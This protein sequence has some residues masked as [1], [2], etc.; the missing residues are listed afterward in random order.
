MTT[1]HLDP[2]RVVVCV[3]ARD[4]A[5]RLPRLIDA[6][7]SQDWP[8]PF[9]VV[10]A[11][12]NT[13]DASR[14]VMDGLTARLRGR[15]AVHVDETV[16]PPELAHAGSARRRAM[17][18]GLAMLGNDDGV[19]VTTDADACPPP[20]WVSANVAAIERGVDLVGGALVLDE[21]EPVSTLV[22]ARWAALAAY[23]AEVR[24]IEDDFDP[25]PWDPPPRHGDNTGG[26]LAVTAAAYRAAGGVP[27]RPTG[28][29]W[30]FVMAAQAAGA[31]L[32]H[33]PDVWVRVS[34]RTAGRASGGMAAAMA[35]LGDPTSHALR[36][37]SFDLWRER[38]LWRRGLRSRVGGDALVATLEP[39]LPPMPC[40]LRLEAP[41]PTE[42]AA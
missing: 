31:R 37:P 1:G 20:H 4:E 5:E 23:W 28:E 26:S 2:R 6:L 11:L 13:T 9:P 39:E 27:L 41:S 30:A 10:V 19:L 38:A 29:D 3:P 25:R 12:N 22:R 21:A 17:D 24:R 36:A 32:S 15:L 8:E 16:F 14:E 42:A 7:A 35:Q 40:D 33:P 34:P 18:L